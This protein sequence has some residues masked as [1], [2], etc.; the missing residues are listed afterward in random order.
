MRM[1]KQL[2]LAEDLEIAKDL[3]ALDAKTTL[4]YRPGYKKYLAAP[5]RR[6]EQF[7]D[8]LEAERRSW[9]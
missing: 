5:E 1:F 4:R 6:I 2:K 7:L 3:Q 9:R 8:S